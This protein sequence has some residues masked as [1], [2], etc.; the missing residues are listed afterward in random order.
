MPLFG[1][2]QVQA[3]VSGLTWSRVVQLE[4]QEWVAKRSDWDPALL[5]D[6]R[7]VHKHTETRMEM[8]TDMNPGMPGGAGFPGQQ[9]PGAGGFPGQQMP[10]MPEAGGGFGQSAPSTRMEPRTHYYYTY[11][12]LEWH[13]GEALRA[14]GASQDGVASQARDLGPGERV[15][16]R[17]ESYSATFS[18]GAKEYEATLPE[19]EWRA[20]TPGGGCTLTLG[21]F[22]GVKKAAPVGG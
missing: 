10:G 5:S 2:R 1:R 6:V 4:R 21:L 12:A 19:Q 15:G 14:W 11:E 9:M 17:T 13:T 16:S 8:V 20:L 22:G 3:R 18:A 7:N